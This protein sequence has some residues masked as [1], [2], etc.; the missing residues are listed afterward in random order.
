MQ[1]NVVVKFYTKQSETRLLLLV[2]KL[3]SKQSQCLRQYRQLEGGNSIYSEKNQKS[4]SE[5]V[6]KVDKF[7]ECLELI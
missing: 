6:V 7:C 2:L 1:T 3:K 5:K 4:L